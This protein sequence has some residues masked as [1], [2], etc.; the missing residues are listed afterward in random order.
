M[1]KQTFQDAEIFFHTE[2]VTPYSNQVSMDIG[3]EDQDATTF[4]ENTRISK[5][6]LRTASGSLSGFWDAR[7]VDGARTQ[8]CLTR[9]TTGTTNLSWSS[10]MGRRLLA[11]WPTS[12][13]PSSRPIS[14]L[15]QL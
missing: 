4:S 3:A 2:R 14:R 11:T 10:R 15:A 9:S 7:S 6:G 13:T 1:A 12:W 8:T 5:T